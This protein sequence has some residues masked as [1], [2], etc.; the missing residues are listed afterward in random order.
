VPR[1]ALVLSGQGWQVT[2]QK[3]GKPAPTPVKAGLILDDEA[4]V[5]EGVAAG[6]RVLLPD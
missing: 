5:R 4:E 3:D 2:L 6:D 1:K